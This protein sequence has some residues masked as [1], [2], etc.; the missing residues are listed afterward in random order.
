[1]KYLVVRL[2]VIGFDTYRSVCMIIRQT[3]RCVSGFRSYNNEERY[4][5]NIV[6]LLLLFT[7]EVKEI[8]LKIIRKK[9]LQLARYF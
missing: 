3:N 6:L 9:I 5:G 8:L 1:M 2:S 7:S 4:A